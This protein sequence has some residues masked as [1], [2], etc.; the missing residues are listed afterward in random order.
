M[1]F[2]RDFLASVDQGHVVST[3]FDLDGMKVIDELRHDVRKFDVQKDS[4]QALLSEYPLGFDLVVMTE[5]LE[6]LEETDVALRNCRALMREDR[7]SRLLLSVPNLASYLGRLELLLGFQPH[8]LE[9]S[10]EIATVGMGLMGRI[11]YGSNPLPLHHLRGFTY[12]SIVEL[13]RY[14][15][16]QITESWGWENRLGRHSKWFPKRLAPQMVFVARLPL[17]D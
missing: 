14:H 16:F 13:L 12:K 15:N 8:V 2:E 7:N 6:H 5:V 3:D 1:R 4:T 17:N 9:A 10:N 11:N